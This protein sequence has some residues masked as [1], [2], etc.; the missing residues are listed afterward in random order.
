MGHQQYS[1]DQ[2]TPWFIATQRPAIN[3]SYQLRMINSREILDA[4]Y[5]GGHW[6]IGYAGA[7]SSLRLDPLKFEWRGLNFDATP[8]TSLWDEN[9][10]IRVL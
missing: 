10:E 1:E 8:T 6:Q 2:M 3:G 9:G 5:T 7:F 4:W